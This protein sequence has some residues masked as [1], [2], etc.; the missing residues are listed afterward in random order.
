MWLNQ[1]SN[2]GTLTYESGAPPTLLCGPA[3]AAKV[4]KVCDIFCLALLFYVHGKHLMSC[5]DG[6]LT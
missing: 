3:N 1:V 6:Q 4:L 5:W 2:P